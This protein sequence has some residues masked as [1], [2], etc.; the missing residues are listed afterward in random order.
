MTAAEIAQLIESQDGILISNCI[1]FCI[2]I[3]FLTVRKN[4]RVRTSYKDL[5]RAPSIVHISVIGIGC[6]RF[7]ALRFA[8]APSL[9]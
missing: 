6:G 8:S 1:C 5:M 3:F 7:C 9:Y 4:V 2:L